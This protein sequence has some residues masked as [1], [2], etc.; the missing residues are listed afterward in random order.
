MIL[1]F[2]FQELRWTLSS[3]DCRQSSCLI[4]QILP[5][6]AAVG[7]PFLCSGL[8]RI[9]NMCNVNKYLDV[10]LFTP[11]CLAADAGLKFII[12]AGLLCP[13]HSSR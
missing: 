12:A 13:S 10:I 1:T 8:V 3:L 6:P 9:E 7:S 2:L 4:I 5:G 11:D